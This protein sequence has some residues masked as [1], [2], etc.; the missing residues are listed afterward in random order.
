MTNDK[1][2]QKLIE[3][4]TLV[5]LAK[6]LNKEALDALLKAFKGEGDWTDFSEA[7]RQQ[8]VT[9]RCSHEAD[10]AME[11]I[12]NLIQSA[13]DAENTKRESNRQSWE[14]VA[15]GMG[16]RPAAEGA[17]SSPNTN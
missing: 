11:S 15:S 4:I 6:K 10:K 1:K 12:C 13:L 3:A 14:N 5:K 17:E 8:M 7:A 2:V 16:M 9:F